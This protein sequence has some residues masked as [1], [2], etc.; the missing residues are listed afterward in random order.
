[1]SDLPHPWSEYARVQEKLARRNRVDPT[2][3]GLE[4][5]L[6]AELTGTT[7]QSSEDLGRI[8][9]SES[10][11]ERHRAR[12]RRT[13][14]PT[15]QP[16]ASPEARLDDRRRL[17]SVRARVTKGDWALFCQIGAGRDYKEISRK[18]KVT[19]GALRTRVSRLRRT[20]A[21]AST[22]SAPNELRMARRCR[23]LNSTG[24]ANQPFQDVA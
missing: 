6:N 16:P 3:W 9:R 1:M 17:T 2:S 5:A 4:A 20:L 23:R 7:L 14:P 18:L 15:N 8:V 24:V 10:R 21:S 13:Y 22:E 11:K 12:L 19:P